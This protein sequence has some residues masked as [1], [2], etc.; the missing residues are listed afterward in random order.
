VRDAGEVDLDEFRNAIR[1]CRAETNLFT[2]SEELSRLTE[3]Q[4]A[5][6][7]LYDDWPQRHEGPSDVG[8]SEGLGGL[9][10]HVKKD[11]KVVEEEEE[12]EESEEH[13]DR[14]HALSPN[15]PRSEFPLLV[16][17]DALAAEIQEL[18]K[19]GELTGYPEWRDDV[20]QAENIFLE[21]PDELPTWLDRMRTK[22]LSKTMKYHKVV[23]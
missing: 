14:R 17:L 9:M 12:G 11:Y 10:E 20:K 15:G 5:A 7:L 8:G 3:K 16:E 23:G 18:E 21:Q 2:G 13:A 6:L 19:K 22:R 4:M 1:T